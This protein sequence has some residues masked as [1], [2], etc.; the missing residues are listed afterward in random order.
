MAYL[1]ITNPSIK[2][3]EILYF[4]W[5]GFTQ[6]DA[7]WVGVVGGGGHWFDSLSGSSGFQIGEAPGNYVLEAYDEM[8]PP[9]ARVTANFT[10]TAVQS[11]GWHPMLW[12]LVTS[13]SLA[14]SAPQSEGWHPMLM[15]VVTS[16]QLLYSAPQSMGWIPM[17]TSIV[18]SSQL[19]YS[20]AQSQGWHPM[21]T[22]IVESAMLKYSAAPSEGWLPMLTNFTDSPTLK[23]PG[24]SEEPEQGTSPWVWAM[25]AG[26]GVLAVASLKQG[27]KQ[28]PAKQLTTKEK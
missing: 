23:V 2:T 5:G 20:V 18:Q 7:V 15:A 8:D 17:L 14:Y 21:L 1:T 16:G 13:G 4:T 22:T 3:G 6:G 9:A 12:S 24:S 10:V 25:A 28:F 26:A 27:N 11:A 19:A